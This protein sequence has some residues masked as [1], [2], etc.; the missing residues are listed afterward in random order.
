[1]SCHNDAVAELERGAAMGEMSP[2]WEASDM[3]ATTESGEV[4]EISDISESGEMS[5]MTEYRSVLLAEGGEDIVRG[6]DEQAKELADALGMVEQMVP[7][8]GREEA[9]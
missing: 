7:V 4:S 3:S 2:S 8:V 5:D 6:H 1:M 9:G